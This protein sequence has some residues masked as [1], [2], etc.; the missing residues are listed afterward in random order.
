MISVGI[1]VRY[2][3]EADMRFHQDAFATALKKASG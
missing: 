3:P 2:V 1:N